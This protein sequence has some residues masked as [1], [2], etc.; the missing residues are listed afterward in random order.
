MAQKSTRRD[1]QPKPTR[2]VHNELSSSVSGHVVQVGQL[3]GDVHMHA[4]APLLVPR[5]LP[6]SPRW[7]TGRSEEL[8]ALTAALEEAADTGGTVVISAIKGTGG[9]GKTWLALYWVHQHLEQFPDGQLFVNLRGFD[10]AARPIRSEAAVRGFLDVLEIDPKRIPTDPDAQA[11]LYRSLVAG[12][13]MV[14]VLDN[15]ADTEQVLPLLPGSSSCTVIVTSRHLLTGLVTAHEARLLP[16]DVLTDAEARE[17][18]TNRAGVARIAAEPN[19]AQELLLCCAGLPL[20]LGIVAARV[21]AYP[22]MSLSALV[23]ELADTSARLAA[24]DGGIRAPIWRRCSPGLTTRCPS[25]LPRC[26]VC[27]GWP[28]DRTSAWPLLL[29]LRVG[30]PSAWASCSA[31]WTAHPLS[32][33]TLRAVGVCTTW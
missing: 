13:R 6:A 2:S 3:S 9:I 27:S 5:Q 11:A 25:K 31:S 26:S 19:A 22:H 7:F 28:Q 4:P 18:L 14:I 20:A 30:Q 1:E 17:L 33:S 24:L 23:A 12:R 10:P 16:L 21:V 32:I 15:A 8:A 29:A